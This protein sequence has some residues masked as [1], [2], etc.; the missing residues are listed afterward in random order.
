MFDVTVV[1][2]VDISPMLWQAVD[3]VIES[4]YGWS[5]VHKRWRSMRVELVF[6]GS[7]GVSGP[8]NWQA[9]SDWQIYQCRTL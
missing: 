9:D 5:G 4:V 1:V 3:I 2:V 7:L 8:Q 6:V